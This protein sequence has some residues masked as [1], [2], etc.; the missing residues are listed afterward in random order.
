LPR[1]RILRSAVKD[2]DEIWL[3]IARD[4]V[5]AAEKMIQ[6]IEEASQNLASMPGMGQKRDDLQPGVRSYPVGRYLIFYRAVRSG[7]EVL[8]VYHGARKYEDLFGSDDA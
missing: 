7:I 5:D 1:A 8:H 2:L 4:S 3:Y 6:R